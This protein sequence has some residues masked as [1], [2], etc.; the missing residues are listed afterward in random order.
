[1]K[2]DY[3]GKTITLDDKLVE[4]HKRVWFG[5]EP[6]ERLFNTYISL[7]YG[8]ESQE[9]FNTVFPNLTNDDLSRICSKWMAEE[10]KNNT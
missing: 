5:M 7:E 9:V 3:K 8:K 2:Y 4:R 6:N 1:M 10:I